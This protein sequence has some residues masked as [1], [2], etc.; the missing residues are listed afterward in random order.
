MTPIF[1]RIW[2]MKIRHVLRF[3][4]DA[5]QL[6]QSLRHQPSLQSHVRVAHFAFEL[7]FRHQRGHRVDDDDVDRV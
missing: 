2:L 1:S 4:T 5:G 3:E 7:R 6:A